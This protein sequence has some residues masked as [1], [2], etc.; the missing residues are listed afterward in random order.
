MGTDLPT[1]EA[2]PDEK[3]SP[4]KRDSDRETK[5]P[6]TGAKTNSAVE[7]ED[8]Y[9]LDSP[10][11]IDAN[12]GALERNVKKVGVPPTG[13]KTNTGVEPEDDY[14]LDIGKDADEDE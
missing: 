3:E 7:P 10:I 12:D 13:A 11:E 5:V 8:N 9:D 2:M 1:E 4:K 6:P 14:D